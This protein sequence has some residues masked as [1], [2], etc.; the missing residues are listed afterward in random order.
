MTYTFGTHIGVFF[1]CDMV[2]FYVRVVRAYWQQS[3]TN[4]HI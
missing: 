2:N 3:Q 4:I 1:L